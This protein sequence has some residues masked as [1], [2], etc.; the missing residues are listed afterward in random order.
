MKIVSARKSAESA[1][2]IGKI[3]GTDEENGKYF[4]SSR[5]QPSTGL[6]EGGER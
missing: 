4:F 2:K 6:R 5:V 3:Y 1:A